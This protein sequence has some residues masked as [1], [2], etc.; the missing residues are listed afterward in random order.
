M[1]VCVVCI[2][3]TISLHNCE[4]AKNYGVALAKSILFYDAQR[5]GKL[6]ANNPI[7]WRGDSALHDCVVGGWYDAGDHIKFGLPMSYTATALL[8]SVV[9]FKDG[10]Q[11]ANQL[12]EM[13][14]M[15]KWPLDYFLKAWKPAQNELVVQVGDTH[16]HDF[17]GRAED[18]TMNR[19]CA[20]VT[21]THKG[22]DIAAGTAAALAAGSI[23]FKGKGDTAYSDQLLNAAKSLYAFAKSHRFVCCPNCL[24]VRVCTK[25][26]PSSMTP[27]G[28]RTSCVRASV[29]LHR[30][31]Q[32]AHYLTDAK[33]FVEHEAAWAYSWDDK[34]VACHL[35]MYE[36]TKENQYK[37]LVTAYFHDWMPGGSVAYTPCGL[38]WRDKW[39][40]N[41][42][43]GNSAFIALVAAEAGINPAAYRKW[44]V[45]QINYL[46][47]DN[48]HAGGCFSFEVGYGNKYPLHPHHAGASCPNKPATCGWPQY[49]STAPNPQILQGALVGGPDQHDNYHDVRSDYVQNEVTTDYNSGFQGALAGIV[50]L[51]AANHFPTTNN[52]CPCAA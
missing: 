31:T 18:M 6:P 45:E 21:A 27:A 2:L 19:P 5:S 8:W 32:E 25:G 36:E 17:W 42:Y 13:Y 28:T 35:L 33:S 30:A 40:S 29:W 16:D 37:D 11:R 38:A 39:G 12:D 14:D 4:A 51:Q 46:L 49:E 23:V 48:H 52:K 43:A 50:H 1:K 41:S 15:I 44:A 22:S 3:M 10:Y 26:P 9:R 24:A 47:G 34:Q 7:H 20:V